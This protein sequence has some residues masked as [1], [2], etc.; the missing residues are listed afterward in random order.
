MQHTKAR[1]VS[2]MVV[3][4]PFLMAFMRVSCTEGDP[5]DP[6]CE[7]NNG[8]LCVWVWPHQTC[9]CYCGAGTLMM[10]VQDES[11]N[12]VKQATWPLTLRHDGN[13]QEVCTDG[14]GFATLPTCQTLLVTLAFVCQDAACQDYEFRPFSTEVVIP[15]GGTERL[16]LQLNCGG[17]NI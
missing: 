10:I 7:S 16:S 11:D 12:V 3:V 2:L 8:R 14:P 4:V 15:C 1:V 5:C 6:P 13:V 17:W 9:Q